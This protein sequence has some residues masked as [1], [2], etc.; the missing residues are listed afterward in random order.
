M[1]CSVLL[2]GSRALSARWAG[3]PVGVLYRPH[4]GAFSQVGFAQ[5][6]APRHMCVCVCT[7]ASGFEQELVL[8][9][10]AMVRNIIT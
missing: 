6:L 1:L 5:Q 10:R 4:A 2:C 3:T 7:R 8:E 9:I